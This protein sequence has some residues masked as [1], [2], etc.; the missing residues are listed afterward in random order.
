M[1][2]YKQ[3]NS[4]SHIS[5]EE[6]DDEGHTHFG[7]LSKGFQSLLKAFSWSHDTQWGVTHC[8]VFLTVPKQRKLFYCSLSINKTRTQKGIC[9]G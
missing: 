7:W 5:R 1:I 8:C 6:S 9:S 2:H 4:E 3:I